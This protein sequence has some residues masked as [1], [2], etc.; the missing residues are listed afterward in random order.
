M[1]SSDRRTATVFSSKEEA[2]EEVQLLVQVVCCPSV[3]LEM[4]DF[5]PLEAMVQLLSLE[6]LL[7]VMEVL[8]AKPAFA[9]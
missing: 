5:W 8:V 6:L 9:D 2:L 1:V 7:A 3:D 4:E